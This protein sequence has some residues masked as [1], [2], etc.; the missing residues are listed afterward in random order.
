M[1]IGC[2]LGVGVTK[3]VIGDAGAAVAGTGRGTTSVSDV[4]LVH[5]RSKDTSD[6]MDKMDCQELNAATY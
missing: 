1:Q 6:E 4:W 2:W 5:T 3:R